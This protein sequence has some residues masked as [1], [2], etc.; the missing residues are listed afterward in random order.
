MKIKHGFIQYKNENKESNNADSSALVGIRLLKCLYIMWVKYIKTKQAIRAK[1]ERMEKRRE[2]V[3]QDQVEIPA[4]ALDVIESEVLG[5]GGFGTVYLADLGS[6][7]N[8]AAKVVMFRPVRSND[9]D[10]NDDDESSISSNESE[11]QQLQLAQAPEEGTGKPDRDERVYMESPKVTGG[12]GGGDGEQGGEGA[13]FAPAVVD[14]VDQKVRRRAVVAKARRVAREART[15][16]RQR[17]A[18]VR[19]L[20]A[21]KRL[22][23]P[24]TVHTYG[25]VATRDR[26]CVV[27]VDSHLVTA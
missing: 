24:H 13:G 19:E 11:Q 25:A 1:A 2:S 21:M 10:N 17:Q 14:P 3:L 6:G 7:L 20:E 16:A 26:V 8:A 23:G 15:D 9:K 22:R 27:V 18:F 12:G 4:A 5:V